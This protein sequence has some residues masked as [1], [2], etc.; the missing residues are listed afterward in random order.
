M[1]LVGQRGTE[2]GHDAVTGEL[3]DRPL[4]LVDLVHEDLEAPIHDPV[5]LLRVELLGDGG[6]VRH[7][8]KEDGDEL[9]LPFHRAS[10]GEDLLG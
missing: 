8:R 10:G 1:I 3:V 2:K 5:D 4:V 6:E 9:A 7:I